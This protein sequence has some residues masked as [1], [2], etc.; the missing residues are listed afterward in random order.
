VEKPKNFL[1][2][3]FDQGAIFNTHPLTLKGS[4]DAT[5]N[6]TGKLKISSL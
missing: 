6:F 2:E 4:Y 1:F 5:V 3:T